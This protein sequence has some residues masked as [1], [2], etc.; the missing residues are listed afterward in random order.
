MTNGS[1]ETRLAR[2]LLTSSYTTQYCTTGVASSELLMNRKL[3][4][5][6]DAMLPDLE[7]KVMR[8]QQRMKE[9]YDRKSKAR[10]INIGDPVFVKTHER[11]GPKYTPAVMQ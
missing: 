8:R 2:Y 1:M 10:S 9:C 6:L 5:Q 7:A 3:R 11:T 4:T